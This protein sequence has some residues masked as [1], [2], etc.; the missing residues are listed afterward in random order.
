MEKQQKASLSDV[1]TVYGGPEGKLWELLM[2]QQIHIGGLTSSIDLAQKAAIQPG[3]MG[4][5]FC[6]CTGAGMRFLVRF[7]GVAA[8]TG[9]DATEAIVKLGKKRCQEENSDDR[10]QFVL[11]DVC[12]SGLAADSADFVWGEDAWCYVEDKTTLIAEACRIVRPG[13]TIAFTDW[14]LGDV[15]ITPDELQRTLGFMKFPS[16][17]SRNRYAALL[18]DNGCTVTHTENTGRFADHVD[19]Y[20]KM[21]GMQLTYDALRIIGYDQAMLKAIGE[22]MT[23]MHTLAREGKIIQGLFVARKQ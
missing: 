8:M 16:L 1:Q 14:V 21:V 23:A 22:E 18:K 13:G 4:V 12:N 5:D 15:P 10:I 19:L 17:Q 11:A 3:S 2:G 6:C 7:C 9:V 20:L